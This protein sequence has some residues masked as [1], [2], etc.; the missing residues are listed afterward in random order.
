MILSGP[1]VNY[2]TLKARGDVETLQQ[3]FNSITGRTDLIVKE[4][5]NW[6]GEWR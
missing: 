2:D 1:E 4:V 5:T 6:Q 3:E